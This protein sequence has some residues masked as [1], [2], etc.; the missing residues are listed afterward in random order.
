MIARIHTATIQGIEGIPVQVETDMR[1][2]LPAL[3]VVGMGNKAVDEARERVRSALRNSL[4]DIPARKFTISLAPAAIPKDG[5][6]FDL[7]IALS[8]LVAS[9]QLRSEDVAGGIFLGELS[10]DGSVKPIQNIV[11]LTEVTTHSEYMQLYVPHSQAELCASLGTF[12]VIGVRTLQELFLHLKG[13]NPI[14]PT[15]AQRTPQEATQEPLLIN[16]IQGQESA[17]RA[18]TIAIAG[19]HNILLYGPPGS[20][21]SMLA[22][23]A[24]QLLPALNPDEQR[25]VAKLHSLSRSLTDLQ[26]IE[27]PFRS[28]HPHLTRSALIGGGT[29]LQ[30]GE[31]S[32][33]HLG[34]LF[35]DELPEYPRNILESLRQPLEDRHITL[36]RQ[37]GSVQLP[38]DVLLIATMNPCPCGH[39]GDSTT[40]CICT[41]G[42][43]DAYRRRLSGPLLDRID[44]IVPV[45]KI[46]TDLL[47]D[48][49]T[50]TKNQQTKEIT[51]INTA[52]HAQC[53]RY[54]SSMVYNA[55]LTN[56][57][58]NTHLQLDIEAQRLIKTAAKKL[59]L[60]ARALYKT[61]KVAQTICDT[62]GGT[63]IQKQHIAEALQYRG[64]FL[65]S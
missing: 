43:V 26:Y 3:Q 39:Y 37:Y 6:H 33:A 4:F 2:G 51:L 23:A 13:I 52:K 5:S 32:L 25:Q 53:L 34:V 48:K 16:A 17:K 14:E 60:S 35:L 18:L 55:S 36:A 41:P 59:A 63:I 29:K 12:Q 9:Q 45:S 19:R 54:K 21:K 47:L 50:L 7:P 42:Q 38:A 56:Q 8:I 62:E 31:L 1:Q 15:T 65:G 61:I 40:A 11:S 27:R 28:P 24:H 57:H 20:G 22:K 44:L 49:N 64:S 58:I 10:L 46:D 30:P